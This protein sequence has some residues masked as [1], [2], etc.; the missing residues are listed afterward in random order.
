MYLCT[1]RTKEEM[2]Y[3]LIQQKV[4]EWFRQ[5]D[6]P[7]RRLVDYIMQ[8]GMMR[9]AQIAA[10]RTFLYLKIACGNQ[11]LASL[12]CEGRFNGP[13]PD[14]DDMPLSTAARSLVRANHQG[15]Q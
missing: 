7:A 13:A 5:D 9:D 12:F 6:C 14:Y 8:R 10:I 3:Q 11:P 2:F 4:E 15:E 1:E